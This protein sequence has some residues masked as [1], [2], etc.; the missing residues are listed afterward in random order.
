[1]KKKIDEI[2]QILKSEIAPDIGI[3]TG[4]GG[5]MLFCSK[6]SAHKEISQS[7]LAH[8][9]NV[10][11][12]RLMDE[13]YRS[14]H[15][16]GLAG[17]GWLYEYLSQRKTI[18]YDTN[19]LLEEFDFYLEKALK[20]FMTDKYYDFLHGAVGVALYF[21]KRIIKKK[22]LLYV[23]NSF[24]EDLEAISISQEDG[25]IKWISTLG[26]HDPKWGYNISL[27][28]GMASIV[29]ILAKLY[30]I[31]GIDRGKTEKLL[32]GAVKYVLAQEIDK[33]KYGSHFT[34]FALEST[35]TIH[36]SRLAWCYGDLGIA[37]ALYQAGIALQENTWINKA[38]EI[39]L[40][41][42][43]KRQN[44]KD[45]LAIDAALCHGT[46]GIA[47]I[48]YRIWWNTKLPEFKSA[49]GYW[50]NQTLKMAKLEDGLAG[51]KVFEALDGDPK[52]VSRYGLLDG[53]SGIGLALLTYYYEMEPEWDECLLL[54]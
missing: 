16:S 15:C 2:T 6:L 54:S 12:E 30:K 31:N 45:S 22:E 3:L 11:E 1:M 10:L 25:A 27:S 13:S 17:I 9:R 46:A 5:Q 41:T 21:T 48:F 19:A 43:T 20:I 29:V 49:A 34:N 47:H 38:L 35:S 23:L 40:F 37:S 32:R 8:L 53:I 7:W 24:L 42:I 28:H 52:W 39:F 36:K 51:Y 14:T 26:N 44:L 33:D 50:F 18:D 4:L